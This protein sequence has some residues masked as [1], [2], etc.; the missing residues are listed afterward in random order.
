MRSIS[1]P[2]VGEHKL[3]I[4]W[5]TYAEVRNVYRSGCLTV[6]DLQD[7]LCHEK[8]LQG[9]KLDAKRAEKQR[10]Q[11]KGGAS[12]ILNIGRCDNGD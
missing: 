10:E 9:G 4:C 11:T 2:C 5:N 1:L 6:G 7:E 3:S 8:S 12:L